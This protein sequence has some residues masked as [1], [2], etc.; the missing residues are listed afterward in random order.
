MNRCNRVNSM[1]KMVL[2]C[3]VDCEKCME[4]YSEIICKAVEK[5]IEARASP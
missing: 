5:V 2:Y 1:Y 3:K 4:K